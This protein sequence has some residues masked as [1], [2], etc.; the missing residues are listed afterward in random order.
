MI[1]LT[2]VLILYI[3]FDFL[4]LILMNFSFRHGLESGGTWIIPT[5]Q[6][7]AALLILVPMGTAFWLM[8]K[9][10]DVKPIKLQMRTYYA[11]VFPTVIVLIVFV[12][13]MLKK[14]VL[15]VYGYQAKNRKAQA[16]DSRT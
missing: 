4:W 14:Y 1:N 15:E 5:F 3:L 7:L 9:K 6:S 11:I 10:M 2:G 12:S 16:R 13:L 8:F